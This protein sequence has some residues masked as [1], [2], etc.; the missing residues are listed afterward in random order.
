MSVE[1]KWDKGDFRISLSQ[2]H[3]KGV[4]E[5][6]SLNSYTVNMSGGIQFSEKLRFDANINYNK[7]DSPNFPSVGYGRPSNSGPQAPQNSSVELPTR[8]CP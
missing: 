7:M 1:T 3:Q 2:M 5:N 4:F 6:T 8:Y